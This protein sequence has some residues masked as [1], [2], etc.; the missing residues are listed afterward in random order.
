MGSTAPPRRRSGA[1]ME[2]KQVLSGKSQQ[3]KYSNSEA[4]THGGD[5]LSAWR[6]LHRSYVDGTPGRLDAGEP[7]RQR[8]RPRW[9][10][11]KDG[12]SSSKYV[13]RHRGQRRNS[14]STLARRD[15]LRLVAP[16]PIVLSG[17][18]LGQAP[19]LP[20][21]LGSIH[22]ACDPITKFPCFSPI[23]FPLWANRLPDSSAG[24]ASFS[25]AETALLP[26]CVG[27]N[28][29]DEGKAT[30]QQPAG[31]KKGR[32]PAGGRQEGLERASGGQA[33]ATSREIISSGNATATANATPLQS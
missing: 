6:R 15:W 33:T 31:R 1:D 30:G 7:A 17:L 13:L 25:G 29:R 23:C 27:H 8:R 21:L 2:K 5:A 14:C 20:T 3:V 12:K 16:G 19:H 4:D 26:I 18:F 32:L 11:T 9:T 10:D 24:G 22:P 28:A